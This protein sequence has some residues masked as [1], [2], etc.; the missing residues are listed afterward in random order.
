MTWTAPAVERPSGS[1]TD[2][3]RAMLEGYLAYHRATLLY[4]CAGLTA[5]QLS[6]PANPP[7]IMTLLGLIRHLTDVERI[8]FRRRFAGED[9]A[10]HYKTVDRWN[11]DFECAD[12]ANAEADYARLL[13]E[14]KAVDA[15]AAAA[16]LDDTFLIDDE[17]ASLRMVYLHL[18][19]EY[20]R[21]NGHA[22]ILREHID[23]VTGA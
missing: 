6:E 20:A 15:V 3:E 16:Q 12:A 17:P 8:W 19:G 10:L 18:I 11:A 1:L 13:N 2:T 21:H 9:V 5:E 23:G 22:D 14:W 7:S 4:K